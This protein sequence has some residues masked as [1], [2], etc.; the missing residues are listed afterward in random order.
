MRLRLKT[1]FTL[2]T[3]LLVLTV[4]AVVS[5]VSVAALVRQT[6]RH[7][8]DRAHYVAQLV[9]DEARNALDDAAARGQGPASEKDPD[10]DAFVRRVLQK[11]PRLAAALAAAVGYS[12]TIYEVSIVDRDSVALVSSEPDVAGHLRLPRARLESL[13]QS[14]FIEQLH[15]LYGP[16]QIYEISLPFNLGSRPFGEIRV[17]LNSALLRN[18]IS[19]TLRTATGFALFGVFFSAGLAFLISNITLAPLQKITAQLDRIARGQ[20]DAQPLRSGDELGQVSTKISEIG[21][22]LRDVR[23][24]FSGLRE[25]LSAFTAGMDDAVLVFSAAGQAVL[26]TPAVEKFLGSKPEELVGRTAAQLFPADQ[27]LGRALG[28]TGGRLHAV[29]Q[30]EVALNGG[31]GPQRVR[32]SVREIAGGGSQMGAL[33]T[34]RDLES[35]DRLDSEL[36]VSER[37]AALARV[38]AGV[39]HEVKNPLNSMRLWLENLRE[40]LPADPDAARAAVKVLDTEIDRLDRVVKRFLDFTKPVELHLEDTALAELVAEVLALARPQIERAGVRAGIAQQDSLPPVRVDRALL[41][42][43]LMNLVLNACQA[44]PQGGQLD[45]T[46]RRKADAAEIRVADTGHGIAPEHRRRIFELFFTTRPSGSGLGLATAF[47]IVQL[48]SGSIDFES[49]PGRGTTFILELPLA[50]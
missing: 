17:A 13:A 1:K 29:E 35:L 21:Q 50:R 7:L 49:E 45:V 16:S 12:P 44:M 26:A 14:D 38:T 11:D 8:D 27:P 48:H 5:L 37:M 32:A 4:V 41:Q 42:Q 10:V 40:S 33:V 20:F 36:E 2:T 28:I 24:I 22:Q 19:P 43:A 15:A 23:G 3:A 47:R 9:L 31:S 46:L 18:E 34:L 30:V 25:N 6:F 39:A